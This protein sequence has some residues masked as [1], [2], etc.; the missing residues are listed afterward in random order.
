MKLS[1]TERLFGQSARLSLML[2]AAAVMLLFFLSGHDLWTQEW[3]WAD[4][5]WQMIYSGDYL[6]PY[7]AGAA[8][9]DKPLLSYWLMIGFSY[10]VGGLNSWALRLPPALAGILA[11]YCTYFIG[12]KLVNR[13]VGLIA[14]WMLITTYYFIF[15]G[16]TANSDMLNLAGTML[17]IAW[18]FNHREKSTLTTYAVFFLILAVTSLL[19]G[20]IGAIVPLLAIFP[21]LIKDQ[22]WKKHLRWSIIPALIPAAIVYALPFWASAHFGNQH[23]AES[24]LYEVYR[25]NVLRYFQ[26]FDHKGP[27]YTYVIFL[28]V[29]MLPWAF[30][31]IPAI[32]SLRKRWP[33]MQWGE[34]W[35]VWSTLIIFLFYTLS[36]SRRN[37]YTLPLVPFATLMTADWIAGTSKRMRWAAGTAVTC[38]ILFFLNFGVLQP[39]YYLGGSQEFGKA[40]RVEAS[41]IKPWSSWQIVFLDARSKLTFYIDPAKPVTILN[42]PDQGGEKVRA[43]YTTADLIGNWP[44][45]LQHKP[46]VIFVTRKLYVDKLRPYLKNYKMLETPPCL[47]DRLLHINDE[48]SPV[49]FIPNP[50][51]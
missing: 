12:N 14:A 31:F 50:P 40:L 51:S 49:A 48:D 33:Q 39:L 24:G 37:Y 42:L 2:F 10:L 15:W 6:H 46:D 22:N 28:P 9:Y 23:Y 44:I 29:Y 20:L 27:I 4:I 11:I 26:P 35:M 13:R 38:F 8:Y 5:S 36:G 1:I 3:R 17:A 19:K 41:S 45:V 16:R 43:N 32:I 47:G 7:L 34:R 21:D 18:Y 30:F 25:E